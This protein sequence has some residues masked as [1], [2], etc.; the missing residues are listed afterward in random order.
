MKNKSQ[1]RTYPLWL[2]LPGL[3]IYTL[4]FIIPIITAFAYSLT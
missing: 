1:D 2:S 4:F 3:F